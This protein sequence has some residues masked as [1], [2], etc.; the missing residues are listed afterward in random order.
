MVIRCSGHRLY[1]A[2]QPSERKFCDSGPLFECLLLEAITNEQGQQN[3]VNVSVDQG[4]NASRWECYNRPLYAFQTGHY[5]I[6]Y[7][8]LCLPLMRHRVQGPCFCSSSGSFFSNSLNASFENK[9]KFYQ[10]SIESDCLSHYS[11][12]EN[13]IHIKECMI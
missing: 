6:F 1:A 2:L 13:K 9:E 11:P 5:G 12:I 4:M 3:S 8:P 7:H 10:L